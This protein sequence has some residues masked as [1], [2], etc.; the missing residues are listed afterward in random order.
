M[1]KVKINVTLDE[2]LMRRIDEY[3]EEN[4]LSRSSLISL[5]T[6]QFLSSAEVAKSIKEIAFSM[7]K[8]ADTGV[9]D[10]EIR[11]SLEDFERLA[12]MLAGA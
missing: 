5:A 1:A 11:R 3:T 9:V 2:D 6:T 8:I 4:Y 12:K 7:R 10:D